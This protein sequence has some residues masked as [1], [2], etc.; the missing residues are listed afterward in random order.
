MF[1]QK[2]SILGTV[3]VPGNYGG[4]ETL[5]ENLVHFHESQYSD[6]SLD[7]YC[8]SKSF[9]VHA[10]KLKNANL[11]YINLEAN[12]PQSVLYDTVSLFQAVRRRSDVILLLGVSGALALPLV[13]LLSQ[14]QI[15]TNI[16]GIEWRRAKWR[17][18][19]RLILRWS[20]RSAIRWSHRVVADNS[21]IADYVRETYGKECHIIPYGGDHAVKRAPI[22][23]PNLKLPKS[24]SL[25][26]CRIEPEN[27]ASMILE[28]FARMPEHPL[29]F[30]GN[31]NKSDFGRALRTRYSSVP[32]LYL[33]DPI[34]NQQHLRW[35]RNSASA[36]VHGH[37]A[38]GTNPSL[39]EMMH[40]G[41]P[42][43][44]HGCIFN[45]ITTE[46]KAR[47]FMSAQELRDQVQSMNRALNNETGTLMRKIARRRY[48]W[49]LIGREYFGLFEAC[50][51]R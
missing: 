14:C 40:F 4:F 6:V 44:A 15:I 13:R 48:R 28:A 41:V 10:P 50:S 47:Y 49:D 24:Y 38:G 51:K 42:V 2:W 18:L 43:F 39:V 45:R 25:A 29:V 35:L 12:G 23:I 31:W 26:L 3:G 27:N 7:V 21:A 22:E 32:N 37:S 1:S 30:V 11:F 8:S 16:D 34:Y 17:R 5:A 33:L 20:E 46:D 36:Y 9:E 19:A